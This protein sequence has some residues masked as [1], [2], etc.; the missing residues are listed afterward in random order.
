MQLNRGFEFWAVKNGV[1][2]TIDGRFYDNEI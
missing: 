2:I 1:K